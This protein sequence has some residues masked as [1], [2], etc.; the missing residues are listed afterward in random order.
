MNPPPPTAPP[1]PGVPHTLLYAGLIYPACLA[2]I[3]M[4]LSCLAIYLSMCPETQQNT[5]IYSFVLYAVSLLIVLTG[6][7]LF[8]ASYC[9]NKKGVLARGWRTMLRNSLWGFLVPMIMA[10][11]LFIVLPFRI[12]GLC[13]LLS[14][15]LAYIVS[16]GIYGRFRWP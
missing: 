15:T 10:M 11:L 6:C 12:T 13:I 3:S 8:V 16:L 9:E 4:P 14:Y 2:C 7:M 5:G 1:A